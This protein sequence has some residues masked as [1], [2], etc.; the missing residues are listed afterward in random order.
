[1][2]GL[3]KD[4][5]PIFILL[6]LILIVDLAALKHTKHNNEKRECWIAYEQY[7]LFSLTRRIKMDSSAS[8]SGARPNY[9]LKFTLAGHTKAVSAV[10][11]SPNGDWLA[12]SSADK[13]IKV[14]FDWPIINLLI[15]ASTFRSGARMMANLKRQY[16]DTNWA[17]PTWPGRVIHDFWSAHPTTRPSRFGKWAQEN[18]S[19]P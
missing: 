4:Y 7:C 10:K 6:L 8:K 18:A 16:P 5:C 15:S 19:R 14:S 1:M 3:S 13:L 2:T 11:F 12:S 17:S 9:N